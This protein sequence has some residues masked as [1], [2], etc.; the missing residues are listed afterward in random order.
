M[1]LLLHLTLEMDEKVVV[2]LG[3]LNVGPDNL[4]CIQNGEATRPVDSLLEQ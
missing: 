4:L 1:D 3:K 2:L